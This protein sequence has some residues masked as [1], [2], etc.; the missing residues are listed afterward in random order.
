MLS[1]FSSD[2]Y[3]P[4]QSKKFLDSFSIKQSTNY[5]GFGIA[6]LV[7]YYFVFTT[8]NGLA[9]HFIRYEKYKGVS[10]KA[11]TDNAHED[12]NVY[13]QVKT[14]G[15]AVAANKSPES[16]GLPFTPSN[17]CIKDLEYFVTLPS[18]EEKQLLRGITAHFEPGRMVALMGAT[19][20]A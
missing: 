18:G 1:E 10:V 15:A 3:T 19:G 16:G 5:I 8:L 14:P 4:E 7:I 2:R 20:A 12:D 6:V 9:L 11:M 17:L 13:V